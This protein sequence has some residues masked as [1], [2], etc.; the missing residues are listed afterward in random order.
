MNS[1]NSFYDILSE[2]LDRHVPL[3][4]IIKKEG[5]WGDST[6]FLTTKFFYY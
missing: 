2:I 3:I 6:N 1:F 4:K 5:M